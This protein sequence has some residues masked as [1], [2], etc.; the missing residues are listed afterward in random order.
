MRFI[1][2]ILFS[3][4][5]VNTNAQQVKVL[6]RGSNLPIENVTIYN[7]SNDSYV[8]TNKDGI[9]DLSVFKNSDILSFNHLS[10]VCLL[11][12]SPSPRD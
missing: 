11:Y 8:Y 6:E 7:D 9:A 10:Y 2:I 12:T 5:Y 3:I 4:L 1:T